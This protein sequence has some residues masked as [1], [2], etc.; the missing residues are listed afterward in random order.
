MVFPLPR[1]ARRPR[2]GQTLFAPTGGARRDG[3][4]HDRGVDGERSR[5]LLRRVRDARRD[6]RVQIA[7]LT[8]FPNE[9]WMTQ[10]AQNLTLADVVFLADHRYLIHDRDG[11]YCPAF[12][13]TVRDGGVRPVRLPPRSPNLNPHAERWVRSV[14]DECL[15]KLILFGEPALRTALRAYTDHFHGERNHPG[16]TTCSSF[17][18]SRW[19]RPVRCAAT[20][21]SGGS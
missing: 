10:I 8:P 1:N 19:A 7:G 3:F 16:R 18:A 11:K 20:S 2:R 15:S 4:L 6:P 17:R 14:K 5:D 12:D 21:A 9:V 13:E